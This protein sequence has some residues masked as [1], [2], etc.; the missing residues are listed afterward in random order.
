MAKILVVEDD[1][2]ISKL[3]KLRLELAGHTVIEA[4]DAYQGVKQTRKEKPD[5]VILD[6]MLPAGGGTSVLENIRALPEGKRVPV[7]VVTC[8]QDPG[9]RQLVLDLGVEAIF[10]KSGNWDSIIATIHGI[11]QNRGK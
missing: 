6:L 11:L 2:D 4:V 7:V 10:D 1:P 3:Y 9:I 5:L 8:V